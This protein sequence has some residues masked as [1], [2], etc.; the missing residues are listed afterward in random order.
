MIP[1]KLM[2]LLIEAVIISVNFL[3]SSTICPTFSA[4]VRIYGSLWNTSFHL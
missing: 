3:W 2:G 1:Q 4:V